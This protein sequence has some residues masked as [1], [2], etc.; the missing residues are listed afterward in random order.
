MA[1]I[2]YEIQIIS[3]SAYPEYAGQKDVVFKVVWSMNGT[4]G[5]R[6]ARHI[7]QTDVQYKSDDAFTE[8]DLLRPWLVS[9]WLYEKLGS[10]YMNTIRGYVA[11]Q[12][13]DQ[14]TPVVETKPLP[15]N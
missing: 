7:S 4:D 15:W 8:Y 13:A 11:N 12:I 3:L 2:S 1:D 10:E 5:V 9:Q 14:I 6:K